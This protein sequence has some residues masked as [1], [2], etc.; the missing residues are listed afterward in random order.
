MTGIVLASASATRRTLLEQAGVV[1]TVDPAAVDE[2]EVKAAMRADGASAGDVAEALGEVKAM[3]I[4]RRHPGALVVGADQ[5][6]DCNGVWFDKPPDRDH[7]RAQLIALRGRSHELVASAVAVRDGR[8][9]WHHTNRVRMTMRPFTDAFLDD[10]LAAMG[11]AVTGTVGGYQLEGRGAQLFSRVDG[12]FFTV[13]GLPLLPLL[14]FLR[15][16]RILGS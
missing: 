12:D 1:V 7:A 15:A 10:Y 2:A 14:D 16:Q 5:M 4:A 11:D 3:R 8:R 13:L 9:L 6:L